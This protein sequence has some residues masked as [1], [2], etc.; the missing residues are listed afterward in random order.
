[1]QGG[2][3]LG[4]VNIDIYT[5]KCS[6]DLVL[7]Y[8]QFVQI[9]VYNVFG[10]RMLIDAEKDMESEKKLNFQFEALSFPTGKYILKI[11]GEAFTTQQSFYILN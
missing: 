10:K 3:Q 9:E 1:M 5:L 7:G 6:F 2:Y 11:I 8:P 4:K